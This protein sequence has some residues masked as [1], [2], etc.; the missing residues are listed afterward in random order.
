MK[1]S[2]KGQKAEIVDGVFAKQLKI[3]EP[4]TEFFEPP[5]RFIL[6]RMIGNRNIAPGSGQWYEAS[7]TSVPN[8]QHPK[9]KCWLCEGHVF[10]V[11]FWCRKFAFRLKPIFS[12]ESGEGGEV[13]KIRA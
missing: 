7:N 12:S 13:E 6:Q 4:Q 3:V 10:S 9:H 5:D 11:I 1:Q 2:F 8:S